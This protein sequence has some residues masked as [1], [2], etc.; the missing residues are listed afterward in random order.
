M[1]VIVGLGNPGEKY[2]KNRHNVGFIILDKWVKDRGL[3][4]KFEKKFN[5]EVASGGKLLFIKPQTFMNSSGEAVSKILNFYKIP[6]ENLLVVHDDVD[7]QIGTTKRQIGRGSAGHKGVES[8]I[9]DALGTPQ[10]WRLRVGVGKSPDPKIITDDW[11]LMDL[12][13]QEI[14]NLH[15]LS[16]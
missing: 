10:F 15:T 12:S 6:P 14:K 5:A 16:Y 11:V 2:V 4:W 8:I 9:E 7:L 1:K 13:E 3:E